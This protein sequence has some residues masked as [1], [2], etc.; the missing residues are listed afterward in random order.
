[1]MTFIANVFPKLRTPKKVVRYMSKNSRLT[2][3]F[4]KKHGK[5]AETLF[6]SERL[7]FYHIF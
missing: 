4:K 1:M 7:Q 5:G 6:T 3:P 2:V